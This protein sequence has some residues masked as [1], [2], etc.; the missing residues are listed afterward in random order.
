MTRHVFAV[1]STVIL[2][3]LAESKTGSAPVSFLYLPL[4]LTLGI[5]LD[6]FHR[7]TV[8]LKSKD[9]I[10]G[11]DDVIEITDSGRAFAALLQKDKMKIKEGERP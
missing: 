6:T 10:V 11:H 8:M 5:G 2:E 4:N 3:T 7:V 9:L 1:V